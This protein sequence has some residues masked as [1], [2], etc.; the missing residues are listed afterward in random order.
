MYRF[1]HDEHAAYARL[2]A[3]TVVTLEARQTQAPAKRA[4]YKIPLIC[5][6]LGIDCIDLVGLLDGLGRRV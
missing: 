2:T 1:I 6:E 4:N 3:K 5:R